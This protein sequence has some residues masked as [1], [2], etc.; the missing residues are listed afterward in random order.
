MK[1][2]L[3]Q[4]IAHRISVP[5]AVLF[6]NALTSLNTD[7]T[8]FTFD[9]I[10]VGPSEKVK[11]VTFRRMHP[12]I[13]SLLR[14]L[15]KVL[16]RWPVLDFTLWANTFLTLSLVPR[17]TRKNRYDAIHILESHPHFVPLIFLAL[18]IK[19]HALS[20]TV[21]TSIKYSRNELNQKLK[22]AFK[23]R[24]FRRLRGLATQKVC[25][26]RPINAIEKFLFLKAGKRNQIGFI[27]ES[28]HVAD[29]YKD[30]LFNGKFNYI[31]VGIAGT[32]E[33]LPRSAAR[34]HLKLP[35]NGPILLSF[36]ANHRQKNYAAIFRAASQLPKD[37]TILHAGKID[38][39]VPDNDPEKLA[40][41]YGWADHTL[42][43]DGFIPQED[44]KY[45][46]SAANAIILSYSKEFLHAS[47]VLS[48]AAG[49]NLPVIASDIGQLGEFVKTK[50]LGLTFTPEDP[51]SLQQVISE[52]LKLPEGDYNRMRDNLKAFAASCSWENVAQKHLQLYESLERVSDHE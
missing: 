27:C 33:I 47:G 46:F 4:P 29:A 3:V 17:L 51:V 6:G 42:I 45:Y 21:R 25:N 50:G 36:G 12:V 20:L 44:T 32:F 19:K 13:G 22:E 9:G 14:R 39:N 23:S 31:P 52:F 37:F 24:D 49:Y 48:F 11:Q 43:V 7:V 10:L 38:H 15:E 34:T 40:R 35:D 26:S 2:L 8:L 30:T 1:I 5:D 18:S 41:D 16:N 28:P